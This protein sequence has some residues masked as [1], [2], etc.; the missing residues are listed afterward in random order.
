[1][2]SA[3]SH[4]IIIDNIPQFKGKKSI[5]EIL[6]RKANIIIGVPNLFESM[7]KTCKEKHIDM[8]FAKLYVM[9]GDNVAPDKLI[10]NAKIDFT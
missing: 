8:S 2:H 5:L 4:G 7:V 1:M 3:L 6:N 10:V 9:G